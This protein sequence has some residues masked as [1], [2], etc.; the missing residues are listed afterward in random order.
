VAHRKRFVAV[1]DD[2]VVVMAKYLQGRGRRRRR[3]RR[4]VAG[5]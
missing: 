2:G 5:R 4:I 1:G 3:R